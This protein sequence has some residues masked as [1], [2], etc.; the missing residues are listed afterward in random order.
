MDTFLRF[1]FSFRVRHNSYI[2]NRQLQRVFL[3]FSCYGLTK[4]F[5]LLALY[6]LTKYITTKK[7]EQASA[8]FVNCFGGQ[9]GNLP[10]QKFP[11][12]MALL[13]TLRLLLCWLTNK[14]SSFCSLFSFCSGRRFSIWLLVVIFNFGNSIGLQ[15]RAGRI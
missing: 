10:T 2:L 4:Y 8:L 12:K 1:V 13:A 15:F 5:K 9:L 14:S 6:I 3:F 11:T 7:N